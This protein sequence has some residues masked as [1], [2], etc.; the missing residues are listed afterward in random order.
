MCRFKIG[1][2]S[3]GNKVVRVLLNGKR[4]FVIQTKHNL[5]FTHREHRPIVDEIKD[6][7]ASNGT[8]HQ[9]QMMGLKV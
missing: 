2:D 9:K 8:A 5:P 3:Y 7:V 4:G 1:R 6:F